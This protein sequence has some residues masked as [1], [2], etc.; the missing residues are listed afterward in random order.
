MKLFLKILSGVL[1]F[2]IAAA[3]GLRIYYNDERL[4]QT[5]VPVINESI[6]AQV[7][8]QSMSL[9]LFSTFPNAG[10]SMKGFRLPGNN[11]EEV[12]TLQELILSLKIVPLLSNDIQVAE[13]SLISPEISYRVFEEGTTN[14]DFLLSDE[15]DEEASSEEGLSIAIPELIL[16]NA[17]INYMDESSGTNI[18][19]GGMSGT[20][21]LNYDELIQT[22]LNAMIESLSVQLDGE[23]YLNNLSVS[24][25]QSS[26]LDLDKE[27]LEIQEGKLGIRNLNLNLN[28]SL[29]SWSS[30]TMGVDLT[31]ASESDDFGELLGLVPPEYQDYID[32]LE[33]RGSLKVEGNIK[34]ALAE[35]VIPDFS[36][37]I[38]VQDGYLKNNEL[39]EAIQEIQLSF[40]AD[41]NEISIRDFRA[42]AAQNTLSMAG[43]I[44]DP[45]AD[46]PGFDLNIE[47]DAD[48]SS[49]EKFYPLEDLD[50]QRLAGQLR[51]ALNAKGNIE[52]LDRAQLAGDVALTN[53]LMQYAGVAQPIQNIEADINATNQ[54]LTI[55]KAGFTASGNSV[56]MSGSVNSPLD[57]R[58][59]NLN[60]TG[61]LNIDLSTLSDFYPIDEDTLTLR[62]KLDSRFVL[63][64]KIT[65]LDLQNVLQNSSVRLTNGYI[66]HYT[67]GEPIR[68]VNFTGS[69][70]GKQIQI[71][72]ASFKTGGNTLSV[73]GNVQNYLSENPVFNLNMNGK[74]V[75]SDIENYYSLQPWI[76]TLSGS[77]SL[78]LTARGPAGDPLKI[79]LNGSLGLSDVN[80][81]GGEL[82]LP[83]SN[84]NSSLSITPN[85]LKLNNM[86][87]KFG[88]SDIQL[89]GEMKS[90]LGLMKERVSGNQVPSIQGTYK[91][92]L[93]NLDEMIDWNEETDPNATIPIELPT[94]NA[95]VTAEI[96]QLRVMGILIEKVSGKGA[97]NPVKIQLSDAK[98]TLFDGTASG[99]LVWDVPQPTQTKFN[100]E[101]SLNGISAPS[102]FRETSFLGESN[103]HR[104]LEGALNADISYSSAL[105]P[106]LSPRVSTIKSEGT[107]GVENARIK[108]HPVQ[109]EIAR[110]LK[111]KEL[112]NMALDDW[113]S[114]FTIQN[115]ILTLT[116]LN[117]TSKDI[118]L[119]INGTQHLV[120]DKIDYKAS[121]ALPGRFK[122]GIGNVLSQQAANALEQ[123]DGT[124]A[125][126]LV[127]T[128]TSENPKVR[129]DEEA[130]KQ[131]VEDYLKEKGSNLIKNLFDG[132]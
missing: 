15:S 44:S 117:L 79:S 26:T 83:V 2:I 24:L 56:N 19:A 92:N 111:V 110:L 22:D 43:T 18:Q 58:R 64:G 106:T 35:G 48:L 125:I 114:R 78:N 47:G 52:S 31:V 108:G 71:T 126:P 63:R 82:P 69:V 32:G 9:S 74:A 93:L 124:L 42:K 10:I 76:E 28:G 38:D 112:E 62:G 20:L 131:I 101:G 14:I 127:I 25:L 98:A 102:F 85:A 81:R 16:E 121:I 50:I 128:G 119:E 87:M 54:Q 99:D 51:L 46:N 27:T 88:S 116:N 75:L 6:G 45:M 1:I 113:T 67:V 73:K 72:Q 30:D 80:A 86:S 105:E 17:A 122:K 61:E 97:M 68:D 123:E 7:E 36:F 84:L 5:V 29:N 37:S 21:A 103:I 95:Q 89:S 66:A 8:V 109:M 96:S 11:E 60:I 53:G 70:S 90:Y 118:G 49:I 115:Q 107:F 33:T 130:I 120:N 4:R 34:G 91:S 132:N 100:F 57:E 65:P 23:D 39:P 129:P 3:A 13:L 104:Y 55:R 12:A 40:I 77:A 41:N 94:L 59:R